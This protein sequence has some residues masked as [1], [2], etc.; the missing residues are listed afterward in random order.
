MT[1][2]ALPAQEDAAVHPIA[3]R[4]F[5]ADAFSQWL[6][7]RLLAAGPGHCTLTMT[8]RP[9]MLNGF[10]ILH[11][12]I[13][14]SLAD[15]ALAFAANSRGRHALSIESGISHLR[16]PRAGEILTAQVEELSLGG[17]IAVYQ[18]RVTDGEDKAVALFKGTVF[19]TEREWGEEAGNDSE[20]RGAR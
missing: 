9:Q 12:G 1:D 19:R 5:A 6:G 8:L 14:Y 7:I 17:R 13:S 18:V 16:S 3:A 20:V 15:S 2:A 4:M 10:G 11:G